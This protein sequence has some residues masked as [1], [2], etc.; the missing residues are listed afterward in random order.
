MG[1]AYRGPEEYNSILIYIR[2]Q[3]L[4]L[5][6]LMDV[7]QLWNAA[8][9]G[10]TTFLVTP[11]SRLW[12]GH[13]LFTV[14]VKMY[15]AHR[16]T[17]KIQSLFQKIAGG[18]P[19]PTTASYWVEPKQEEL[20][21]ERYSMLN[22]LFANLAGALD[23]LA[24][25]L[26]YIYDFQGL[27]H[28]HL[29]TRKIRPLK[30]LYFSTVVNFLHDLASKT[31]VPADVINLVNLFRHEDLLSFSTSPGQWTNCV[32]YEDLRSQRNY[33]IHLGFPLLHHFNGDW[34]MSEDPKSATLPTSFSKPLPD[35][36][37]D[38]NNEVRRFIGEVLGCV[39]ADY[40]SK[41]P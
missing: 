9:A 38:L 4:E 1:K 30:E 5:P 19:T 16:L 15:E 32:W 8:N 36:C 33:L 35:Q 11:E 41:L 17:Q 13:A 14:S 37:Q 40:G 23:V 27:E 18:S 29:G 31:S 3:G 28:A 21:F 7:Y 26:A 24:L 12:F 2:S 20:W 6:N 39:W 34:F 10:S 25:M 22:S